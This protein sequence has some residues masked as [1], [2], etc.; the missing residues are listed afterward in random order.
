MN[1]DL[2]AAERVA[3]YRA[4]CVRRTA[5]TD[6]QNKTAPTRDLTDDGLAIAPSNGS[7][8]TPGTNN[9]RSGESSTDNSDV[10]TG[11]GANTLDPASTAQEDSGNQS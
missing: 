5:L 4:R 11:S 6:K 9:T 10:G 2:T 7:A 1:P 8:T 3:A